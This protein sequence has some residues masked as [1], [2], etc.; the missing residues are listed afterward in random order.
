MTDVRTLAD[1]S[2]LITMSFKLAVSNLEVQSARLFLGFADMPGCQFH[3]LTVH[4][5]SW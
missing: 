3:R 4:L 5:F 2:I 1:R